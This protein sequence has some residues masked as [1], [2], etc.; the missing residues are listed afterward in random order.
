MLNIDQRSVYLVIQYFLL[1]QWF[2]SCEC[3]GYNDFGYQ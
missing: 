1:T 3:N 2:V